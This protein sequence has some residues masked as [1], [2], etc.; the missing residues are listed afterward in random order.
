MNRLDKCVVF[1]TSSVTQEKTTYN[2]SHA[3]SFKPRSIKER[4]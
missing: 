1:S 4:L 2:A 3:L